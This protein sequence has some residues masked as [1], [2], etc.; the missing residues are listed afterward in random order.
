MAQRD[1]SDDQETEVIAKVMMEKGVSPR[2]IPSE[3]ETDS[4]DFDSVK[5]SR[6]YFRVKGFA[7]FKR[8]K[9]NSWSG[10]FCSR[11]WP[12]AHAWCVIDLKRQKIVE[13]IG[14]G[15]QKCEGMSF[16]EFD[17]ESLE[18]MAEYAVDS[19]LRKVGKLPPAEPIDDMSILADALEDSKQ[20]HDEKRCGMCQKLGR[21]CWKK[22]SYVV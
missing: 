16:P 7:W 13:K 20:P 12:S 6:R 11:T 3:P 4:D 21:S 10:K 22:S 5:R 17:E 8:H 15:C 2:S 19:Y 14:Q 9:T 1:D 18:R